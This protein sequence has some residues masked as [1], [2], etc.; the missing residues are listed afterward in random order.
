MTSIMEGVVQTGTAQRLKALGRPIA[1]KTG[2]TNDYKDA[3]FVG[4]TPDLAVGAYIG[5]DQ[6]VSMGHGET[7]GTPGRADHP[8]L[9]EGGAEG[10]ASGAVPRASGH[11]AGAR[12]SQDPASPRARATR[13]QFWRPSSR[14]RSPWA[15]PSR[16]PSRAAK[17]SPCAQDDFGGAPP[18]PMGGAAAWPSAGRRPCFDIGYRRPLLD[19]I[20]QS[21][22]LRR[23]HRRLAGHSTLHRARGKDARRNRVGRQ[24]HQRIPG[25]AQE[26]SLTP[27]RPRQGWR[28]STARPRPRASGTTAAAPKA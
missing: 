26:A 2:T 1:G 12:Q 16:R 8:R 20:Y 24:R 28:R 3:W 21:R 19:P 17:A 27:T 22:L 5:Y 10:R 7:G 15:P 11:Q 23:R 25:P 13:P 4:Y 6:P 18:P 9:L 14:A